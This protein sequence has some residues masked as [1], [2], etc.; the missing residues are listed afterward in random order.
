MSLDDW[1]YSFW[2]NHDVMS[3]FMMTDIVFLYHAL[4]LSCLM[5][6]CL[7]T[8][9]SHDVMPWDFLSHDIISTVIHDPS[10]PHLSHDI[11]ECFSLLK[12]YFNFYFFLLSPSFYILLS[13]ISSFLL[14]PSS[15]YIQLPFI[16]NFLLYS[17]SS[18][19]SNFLFWLFVP[20]CF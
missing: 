4:R 20:L 19:I 1:S 8:V 3:C 10:W 17:T 18:F 12:L 16:S 6:S 9:L 14:Y 2:G 11:I 15:F 13:F 7:E 5:M